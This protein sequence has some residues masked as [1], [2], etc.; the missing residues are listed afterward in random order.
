[1]TVQ[2]R[3]LLV[4]DK[5]EDAEALLRSVRERGFTPCQ[6]GTTKVDFIQA[7]LDGARWD[8]VA[9]DCAPD[10]VRRV[11]EAMGET[12]LDVPLI[13]VTN[14]RALPPAPAIRLPRGDI[15]HLLPVIRQW[16]DLDAET[17]LL[18]GGYLYEHLGRAA[19]RAGVSGYGLSLMTV[20]LDHFDQ[21]RET[22]G[23]ER[24]QRILAEAASR[25][26][27]SVREA[28]TVAR[29]SAGTFAV[30]LHDTLDDC[31]AERTA[32]KILVALGDPFF[33]RDRMARISASIGIANFPNNGATPEALALR[34]DRA[35]C[36]ASSE[37][38]NRY[39]TF[40]EAFF[41]DPE[42]R[43]PAPVISLKERARRA[44]R[45]MADGAEYGFAS[46]RTWAAA[47][48]IAIAAWA[49]IAS[50][51]RIVLPGPG[52]MP[53]AVDEMELDIVPAS[54]PEER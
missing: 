35:M 30:V 40:D 39:R 20:A 36:A 54:G 49:L 10:G 22:L 3:L 29:L 17:G 6:A 24:T 32:R 7:A 52:G 12:G 33:V 38:A 4:A 11:A 16:K 34:A 26:R 15:A 50:P 8:A 37:G 9:C 31:Q 42:P 21:I 46:P 51:G 5:A 25:L 18:K 13:A 23:A 19:A 28:D 43:A 53:V 1:M 27:R 48:M 45:R 2:I 41:T 44:A 47:A 14:G